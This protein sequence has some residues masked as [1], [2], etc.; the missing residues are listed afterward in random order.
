MHRD[1]RKTTG[2]KH[3][4]LGSLLLSS[5]LAQTI[6][7]PAVTTAVNAAQSQVSAYLPDLQ[8]APLGKALKLAANA[9]VQVNLFAPRQAH[10]IRGSFLPSVSL[11]AALRPPAPMFYRF[12]QFNSP[13][14]VLIDQRQV[15]VGPGLLDG[16]SAIQLGNAAFLKYALGVT[17]R[18]RQQAQPINPALLIRER[19]GLKQ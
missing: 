19:Y 17:A 1:P 10:L 8:N 9:G 3:I 14:F 18:A 12:A 2:V 13:A 5:A 4:V 16:R 15:Y 7:L 11:A 6:T